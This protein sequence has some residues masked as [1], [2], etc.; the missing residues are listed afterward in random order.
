MNKHHTAHYLIAAVLALLCVWLWFGERAESQQ[1]GR[2]GYFGFGE[3][4]PH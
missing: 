2:I 4:R 3:T 1:I